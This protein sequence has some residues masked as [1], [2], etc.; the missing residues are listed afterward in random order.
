MR[1]EDP[2]PVRL[3]DYRAPDFLVDRVSL[4]VSL[5]PASTLVRARLSMRPNPQGVAGGPLVLDGDELVLE[6]LKLDGAELGPN[7]YA[8]DPQ[9]LVVHD[10]PQGPFELEITTRLAP[11]ANTKLMGLFR[12][13]GTWCTQCEPEGFRRITYFLD[14]PDVLAVYTTR[15][16]AP[17]AVAPVLLSNGNLI[18]SGVL[19][20]DRHF[21][22]WHDPFPKPS[23]LFALVGGDLGVI[24]D[25]FRTAS[26]REVALNI[27]VEHGKKPRAEIGRA[28]V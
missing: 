11:E 8:A 19:D 24:E 15:I 26:G 25:S 17:R 22:V 5:D 4:D 13:G 21:A 14:R 23:Y 18:D 28:H 6:G 10:V 7:R 20:G 2:R 27:F 16:E 9:S 3:V 12:S 1:A